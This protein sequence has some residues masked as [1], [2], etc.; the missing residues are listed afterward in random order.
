MDQLSSRMSLQHEELLKKI[1]MMICLNKK[2][3]KK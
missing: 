1:K 2:V 3:E